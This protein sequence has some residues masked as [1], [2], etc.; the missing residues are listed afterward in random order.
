MVK[1]TIQMIGTF[2]SDTVFLAQ[3]IVNSLVNQST[4]IK[5]SEGKKESFKG[6]T[7]TVYSI[8]SVNYG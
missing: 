3:I 8:S 6:T 5:L 4:N 7:P 2:D 1:F